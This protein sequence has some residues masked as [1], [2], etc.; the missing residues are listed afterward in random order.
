MNVL[1]TWFSDG[2]I[3]ETVDVETLSESEKE[4][5]LEKRQKRIERIMSQTC[6][7]WKDIEYDDYSS[8]TYLGARLA[9]NFATMLTVFNEVRT[10]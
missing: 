4:Y 10:E 5:H 9:P 7:T 1:R 2:N 8:L 3:T 6:V